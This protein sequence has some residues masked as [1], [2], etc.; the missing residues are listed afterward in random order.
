[1]QD[2]TPHYSTPA[3]SIAEHAI[4]RYSYSTPASVKPQTTKQ[5]H[6]PASPKI[7]THNIRQNSHNALSHK[8][9]HLQRR[10]HTS[11]TILKSGSN[12]LAARDRETVNAEPACDTR[13][14]RTP[15]QDTG[16]RGPSDPEQ[17]EWNDR[18]TGHGGLEVCF[19]D[20]LLIRRCSRIDCM[21]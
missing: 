20:C 12:M 3:Y 21:V 18:C 15:H 17:S 8:P 19:W 7:S 11:S 13:V 2:S 16:S 4:H 14:E 1:M 5:R 9:K 10:K 6:N